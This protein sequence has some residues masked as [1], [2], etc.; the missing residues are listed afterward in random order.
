MIIGLFELRAEL[1]SQKIVAPL[2]LPWRSY[3]ILVELVEKAN[4]EECLL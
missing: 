4:I 1:M 3:T 2:I